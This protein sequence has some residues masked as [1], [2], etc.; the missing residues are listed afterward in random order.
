MLGQQEQRAGAA[1]GDEQDAGD[2]A[3]EPL[4][5]EEAHVQ[6]RVRDASSQPTKRGEQKARPSTRTGDG[7]AVIGAG[8]D[9]VHDGGHSGGGERAPTRSG[10]RAGRVL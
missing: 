8:D 9:R 1:E 6:H 4:V 7:P 10:G 5:A 3:D 2:R